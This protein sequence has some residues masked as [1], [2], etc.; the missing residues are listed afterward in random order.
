[1]CHH[2]RI[3]P[4]CAHC[5]REAALERLLGW[6]VLLLLALLAVLSGGG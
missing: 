3:N 1:M 2:S 6:G 4:L 5:Q